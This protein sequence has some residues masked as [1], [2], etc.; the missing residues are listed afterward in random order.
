ML[1]YSIYTITIDLLFFVIDVA[2]I[3]WCKLTISV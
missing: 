3:V 1:S 2:N